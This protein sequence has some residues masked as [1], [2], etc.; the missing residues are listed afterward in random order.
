MFCS[1]CGKRSLE[2]DAKYCSTCGK[3]LNSNQGVGNIAASSVS[4]S[5]NAESTGLHFGLNS[6]PLSLRNRND[7]PMSF[8]D[9]RKRK[10]EKRR[11]NFNPRGKKKA[12]KEP[13]DVTINVGIMRYRDG[14][15]TVTRGRQLPVRVSSNATTEVLLKASVEKHLK[16]DRTLTSTCDYTLIYPDGS[17]V[18]TMPGSQEPFVL[19][20]YK[21]EIG[22]S[23]SRLS[24]NITTKTEF[25]LGEMP[26]ID[27]EDFSDQF[28]S[29]NE[30]ENLMVPAFNFRPRR[31]ET[32]QQL[33]DSP[34]ASTSASSSAQDATNS[35]T[36]HRVQCPV[37]HQYFPLNVIE[38]HSEN[39]GEEW[40][41]VLS[42]EDFENA[43]YNAEKDEI[44]VENVSE[45]S[46]ANLRAVLQSLANEFFNE[47]VIRLN[48]RRKTLWKDFRDCHT[49]NKLS[50]SKQIKI[51]FMHEPAVDDGGPRREFFSGKI[52]DLSLCQISK[53]PELPQRKLLLDLLYKSLKLIPTENMS[54]CG[55]NKTNWITQENTKIKDFSFNPS[56]PVGF[57]FFNQEH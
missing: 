25:L 34:S 33:I 35:H 49:R 12:R 46:P 20:S 48:I 55:F 57:S 40:I 29:E 47:D 27:D 4:T 44:D 9:F 36:Q 38:E 21:D 18:K 50:P 32:H 28:A 1:Q 51:V 8:S 31:V 30:D 11:E 17:E 23:Y 26:H 56:S 3:C 10:E 39:C 43:S 14:K 54:N 19:S 41:G 52:L 13:I 6:A 24:L 2:D 53:C 15:L 37:C 5:V 42:D 45:G 22:K 16:H 7:R